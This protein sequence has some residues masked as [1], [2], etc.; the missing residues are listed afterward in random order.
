MMALD[1]LFSGQI[2]RFPR[3]RDDSIPHHTNVIRYL[4]Y[5]WQLVGD[6]YDPYACA[7]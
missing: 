6:K 3:K 5:F 1:N 2:Y 7:Q 4:A